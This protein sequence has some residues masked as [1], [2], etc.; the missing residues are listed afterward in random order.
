MAWYPA[1]MAQTDYMHYLQSRLEEHPDNK[2]VGRFYKNI[3]GA[4]VLIHLPQCYWDY[5]EWS[6]ARGDIDFQ[7]WVTH[8]EQNPF[9]D[10][11]LS[12]LLMYWLWLDR[13]RRHHVRIYRQSQCMKN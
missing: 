11:S 5:V 6:E 3:A 7:Y 13:C 10:W 4:D 1:W 8:T 12:Q 9:E 2:P